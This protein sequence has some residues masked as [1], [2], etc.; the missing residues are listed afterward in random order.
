[1]V[2][3]RDLQRRRL[4]SAKCLYQIARI[5]HR[6]LKMFAIIRPKAALFCAHWEIQNLVFMFFVKVLST[7]FDGF[8]HG[9]CFSTSKEL[10]ALTMFKIQPYWANFLICIWESIRLSFSPYV[11]EMFATLFMNTSLNP[12]HWTPHWRFGFTNFCK[13]RGIFSFIEPRT[14]CLLPISIVRSSAGTIRAV[15]DTV[16]KVPGLA[17]VLIV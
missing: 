6:I 10:L 11:F 12:I 13:K 15:P 7:F 3:L 5:H 14:L 17:P 9:I 2:L 4:W 16:L 8:C 1:M